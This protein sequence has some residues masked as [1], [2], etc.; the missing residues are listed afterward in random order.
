[1]CNKNLSKILYEDDVEVNQNDVAVVF[2]RL[3]EKIASVSSMPPTRCSCRKNTFGNVSKHL[4]ASIQKVWTGFPK[5]YS[6][7]IAKNSSNLFLDCSRVFSNRTYFL[8]YGK[9]QTQPLSL[10]M[11]NIS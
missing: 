8:A 6:Q 11:R 1:M 5:E 9:L 10:K 3:F 7:M 4:R 2:E